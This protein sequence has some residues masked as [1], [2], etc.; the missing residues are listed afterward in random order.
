MLVKLTPGIVFSSSLLLTEALLQFSSNF[1]GKTQKSSF[2]HIFWSLSLNA[3]VAIW[4]L[5]RPF[6]KLKKIVPFKVCFGKMWAK[7]TIFYKILKNVL[8]ISPKFISSKKNWPLFGLFFIFEKWPFL[9]LQMANFGLFIF[10]DLATL[11]QRLQ[12]V[13]FLVQQLLQ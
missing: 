8:V 6:W 13:F 2:I 5:K 12:L 11:S 7:I 9:K 4:P 10:W 1:F 3:R